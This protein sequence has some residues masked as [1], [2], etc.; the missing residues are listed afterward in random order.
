MKITVF[1]SNQPRHLSLVQSLSSVASQVYFIS[2]VKTV[3]TGLISDKIKQSTIMEEYFSRVRA[4]EKKI[5]NEIRFLPT[6]T[7]ILS[8]KF[9]DLNYLSK[10]Q[11]TEALNSDIYIIFGSSYIKGW[12][13]DFLVN[14]GAY[15]IHMGLSPYYR[16]SACNFWALYDDNAQ[17][18]GSTIHLLSKGLDNGDILFHCLPKLKG[19]E[20]PFEFSMRAVSSAHKG[21]LEE[22]ADNKLKT[23]KPTKQNS[24]NEIRYSRHKEFTDQVAKEYL[25]RENIVVGGKVKYPKLINTKFFD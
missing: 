24:A 15:N 23:L 10:Q 11:L 19:E 22:L 1:S 5:F 16:G 17:F 4:A 20:S 8:I 7:Q 21:L 13:A 25:T 14:K 18:V 6:N 3:F 12:L 9:G 2:E